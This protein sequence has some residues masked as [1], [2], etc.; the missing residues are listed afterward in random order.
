MSAVEATRAEMA[1]MLVTALEASARE[2]DLSETRVPTSG[3]LARVTYAK[4]QFDFPLVSPAGLDCLAKEMEAEIVSL[5]STQP[6][7]TGVG[8][9]AGNSGSSGPYQYKITNA[10]VTAVVEGASRTAADT[11]V[12]ETKETSAIRNAFQKL[13]ATV[14]IRAPY[15]LLAVRD[16]DADEF[17][18]QYHVPVGDAMMRVDGGNEDADEH[19]EDATSEPDAQ[20][21]C[22]RVETRDTNESNV[23]GAN[24]RD[25]EIEN[26]DSDD[27]SDW[28]PL[29][30][31]PSTPF[32]E[33]TTQRNKQ[34]QS[35]E[36]LETRVDRKLGDLLSKARGA[37]LDATAETGERNASSFEGTYCAFPK[38]KASTFAHTRTRRDGYYLCRL[39]ARNYVIH[40]VRKTDTFFYVS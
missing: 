31:D 26:D 40:A 30:S 14:L 24:E 29:E 8:L 4:L 39:S 36:P 7:G 20:L 13:L 17:L 11:T 34:V 23:D 5:A 37:F 9:R 1:S 25:D 22:L 10:L 19:D 33:S 16:T 18:S 28:E 6:S 15:R 21:D 3:E 38:S 32:D 27:G 12:A 2:R 35:D